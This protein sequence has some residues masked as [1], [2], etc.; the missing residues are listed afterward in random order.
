MSHKDRAIRVEGLIITRLAAFLAV[1]AYWGLK[2]ALQYYQQL[3]VEV[4]SPC[5]ALYD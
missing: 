4:I 2:I 3:E 5:S 1:S